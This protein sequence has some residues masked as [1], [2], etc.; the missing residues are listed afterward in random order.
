MIKS[1]FLPPIKIAFVIGKSG[2]TLKNGQKTI[3]VKFSQHG[4]KTV[5]KTTHLNCSCNSFYNGVVQPSDENYLFI[6]EQLNQI[7][8]DK[9]DTLEKIEDIDL[10]DTIEIKISEVINDE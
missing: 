5:Y 10:E 2:Q 7:K 8:S 1:Y 6:N 3:S 4:F 9:K